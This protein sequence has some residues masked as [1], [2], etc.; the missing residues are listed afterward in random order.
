MIY[1]VEY[2]SA[3]KKDYKRILKRG[4]DELLLQKVILNLVNKEKLLA[5]VPVHRLA[6]EFDDCWECHLQPD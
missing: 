1:Q 4:H 5:K 2:T 3:F 6:G